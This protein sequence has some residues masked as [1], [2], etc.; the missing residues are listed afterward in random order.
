[1]LRLKSSSDKC[2]KLHTV[3]ASNKRDHLMMPLYYCLFTPH[4]LYLCVALRF[5]CYL[6]FFA[7]K[8]RPTCHKMTPDKLENGAQCCFSKF[9]W[10]LFISKF[11][12]KAVCILLVFFTLSQ[13][14]KSSLT[15][16]Q[17]FQALGWCYVECAIHHERDLSEEQHPYIRGANK[18]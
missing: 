8:W 7:M 13:F 6:S 4:I 9:D 12:V 15:L 3:T 11:F 18:Q 1:L 2:A 10:R 14:H 5:F 17:V 16:M